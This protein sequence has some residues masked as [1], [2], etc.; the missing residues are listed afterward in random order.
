MIP[1]VMKDNLG[2]ILK[3]TEDSTTLTPYIRVEST[4]N[5]ILSKSSFA[6][7]ADGSK[8]CCTSDLSVAFLLLLASFFVF[9]I[10]Y[11]KKCVSS[12]YF[13]SK[14][15]LKVDEEVDSKEKNKVVA[16]LARLRKC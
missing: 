9:D 13:L 12:L 5:C 7:Y 4:S 10:H 16:F 14:Y 1:C 8:I 6:I 11:P 2:V 15:V 3:E